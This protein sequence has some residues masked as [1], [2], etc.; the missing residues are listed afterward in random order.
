M[1]KVLFKRKTSDEI[2]TL[3]VEDG[4]LIY[5]HET[6]ATYLDYGNE[7]IPTGGGMPTGDTFPIGAIT[8]FY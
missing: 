7:R 3:P 1:T 2:A 6:G 4:A 5:N 8:S